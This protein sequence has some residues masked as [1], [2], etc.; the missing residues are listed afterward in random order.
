MGTRGSWLIGCLV[1]LLGCAG[2]IAGSSRG[3]PLYTAA[4]RPGVDQVA[5]LGG[6]VATVDGREVRSSGTVFELLPGCHF[7]ETPQKWGGENPSGGL[8]AIT[9]THLFVVPM[10]A[11]H[12]YVVVSDTVTLGLNGSLSLRMDE[13]DA[14][15]QPVRSFLPYG[16]PAEIEACRRWRP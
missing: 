14:G 9:G 2:C 15:G 8:V 5:T 4:E 13:T 1:S 11:T 7:I 16:T 12:S 6:Y 10:V 3:V